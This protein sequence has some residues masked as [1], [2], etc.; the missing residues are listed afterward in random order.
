[1]ADIKAAYSSATALTLTSANLASSSTAGWQS[2][3]IDNSS[4]LYD[5]ILIFVDLAAVNTAPTGSIYLFVFGSIDGGTTFA[6]TGDGAPSGSVGTLTFPSVV[7]ANI[8]APML[9]YIPYPVQNKVLRAVFSVAA[10]FGG[11]IPPKFSIGMVNNSGMALSVTSIKWMG[12][13][14]TVA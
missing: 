5:D 13:Y 12:R 11:T 2:D 7:T 8:V 1:M 14:N 10:A 6:S 4:T 3:A 9:G